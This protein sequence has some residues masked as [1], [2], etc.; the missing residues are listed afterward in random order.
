MTATPKTVDKDALARVS[1]GVAITGSSGA[2]TIAAFSDDADSVVARG[3]ADM[4]YTAG[5]GDSINAGS[6]GDSVDS[7]AGDDT[8]DGG[9]GHDLLYGSKGADLL[10]GGTGD[11]VLDG[12]IEDGADDT[13]EGGL[14]SD[15]YFWGPGDGND[16][17]NG[18]QGRDWLI[19]DGVTPL[20]LQEAISLSTPGLTMS[21]GNDGVVRFLGADG[22][23]ATF[24]GTLTLDGHTIHFNDIERI[25]FTS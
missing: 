6:G 3:G 8:V 20:Q 15:A 24:S 1:G 19:L 21:M 23:P 17:F 10:I 5:G 9:S 14:G 18:G 7:G 13:A 25:G 22:K 12:G 2:D 4:I 11:D 16:V